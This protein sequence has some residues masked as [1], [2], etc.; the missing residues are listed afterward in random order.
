MGPKSQQDGL[1]FLGLLPCRRPLRRTPDVR[2]DRIPERKRGRSSRTPSGVDFLDPRRV[3]GTVAPT[4]T[5]SPASTSFSTT[6]R[7]PLSTGVQVIKLSIFVT[8]AEPE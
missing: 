5:P 2:Q 8:D 1:M 3:L 7:T 4:G 6:G